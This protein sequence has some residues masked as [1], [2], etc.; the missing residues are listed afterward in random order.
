MIIPTVVN[1]FRSQ[2]LSVML[3][4]RNFVNSPNQKNFLAFVTGIRHMSTSSSQQFDE[5]QKRLQTLKTSPGNEA[6]LKLYGL[7]KQATV[8]AV[9]TKRPGMTDF[10][11]KAKWDAW[12]SLGSMSQ[13]EA[14]NKYITFVDSLVGPANSNESL[15]AV[16]SSSPGFDV[17]MDG[18]L[19][20]I[21]LNKPKTKNAFTLGMYLDFAK[22]LKEAAE[23][24]NTT[25]V[26]VTGAGNIFSSGNDLT[27][28]T[29]FTGTVR[30]AAEEG[31][32]C[33]NIFVSS[34]IDFPKPIIG[35]VNGPA[36]GIACTILGL[37]DAVYATDRG[38]FQTPFSALGQ[39][40]EA[41]SSHTFPKLMGSLKANE[42]LFFNKTITA[43]EA[44]KLG[45]VTSVLPDANF[46]SEV[47]PNLKEWSELPQKS[48]VHSKELSRQF[49]RELLHK[50]NAA[51]CDRLLE[52]WQ[53]SDCMEAV[54][55]FFS[56]NAK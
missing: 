22:L 7:F 35:V 11:G 51:E 40:P 55:K 38:W 18:K 52:R 49:D 24:P 8:G 46:Q 28:F 45:L 1:L 20:I 37:M 54:L 13:E 41:C 29:S 48:L 10:V 39:S 42:M 21:T 36:V 17:K 3:P 5:A 16:E 56:K 30:E 27:T 44:C 4:K 33:L 34:L 32:R 9:N 43:T 25:L 53:S 12:N 6:K 47:W 15:N 23:D 50:V 31:K 14:K 26:A 19:R 2:C